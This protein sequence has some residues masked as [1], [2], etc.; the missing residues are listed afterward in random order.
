MP[1]HR[2]FTN[3]QQAQLRQEYE[4]GKS[5][6]YLAKEYGVAS[7]TVMRAVIRAGG[8][9]R[10]RSE[11]NLLRRKK[12]DHL[13]AQEL[14]D[15]YKTK[16]SHYCAKKHGCAKQTILKFIR[17]N[18]GTTRAVGENFKK[19]GWHVD[20]HGYLQELVDDS[21][22]YQSMVRATKTARYVLQHRKIM[23]ESLGRAL[24]ADETV[25]HKDG[26]KLNNDL[27]NLQLRQGKHG[28]GVVMRCRCCG[29]M[30]LEPV[31]V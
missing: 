20:G 17:E 22:P 8:T 15:D 28:K 6:A 18:G 21:W 1:N 3:A 27:S 9:P 16:G 30:D 26:N 4:Q 24:R 11:A 10:S 29:S 19:K 25:H 2:K 14:I 13:N 7:D 5:F 12:L 31:D 23:A